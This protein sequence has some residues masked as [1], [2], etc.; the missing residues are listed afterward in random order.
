M[1]LL[2]RPYAI[3]PEIFNLVDQTL[4]L[5]NTNHY[6]QEPIPHITDCICNRSCGSIHDFYSEGDYWWPNPHSQN[7][8]PYVRIDGKTNPENFTEHRLLL[9]SM[10][11]QVSTFALAYYVTQ[12]ETYARRAIQILTEFFLDPKTK[13]NPNLDYSQAIAGICK[14]RGIGII[15]TIHLADVPFA[16]ETL[17]ASS[18]MSTEMYI[19]LQ[20]WFSQ[21]LSWMLSSKNGIEEMNTNNN[22]CICY[23]MQTAVFALFTDNVQITDFCRM[24][25]KTRLLAQMDCKGAFPLELARTKPY[26]YS[27]FALDNLTTICQLLSTEEDNLWTWETPD[28]KSYLKAL[29]FLSPYILDKSS[30]IYPKDIEHFDAFP[31]RYSFLLFAGYALGKCELIDFYHHLPS[32]IKDEEALRNLAIREPALWLLHSPSSF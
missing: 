15:D 20:N 31:I 23:I 7:G 6:L 26:N 12:D 21:Y 1:L 24:Q 16:I 4:L 32:E 30:W 5:H 11:N 9:R 28:H 3:K 25:Y 18:A 19:Q 14:G 29:E 10:R 27:A 8:L 2:N 17:R 22:H 13:M